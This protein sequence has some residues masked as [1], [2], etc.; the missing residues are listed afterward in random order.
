[1]GT[2]T[3]VPYFVLRINQGLTED[4]DIDA[5][6]SLLSSSSSLHRIK[7]LF[8]VPEDLVAALIVHP[9]LCCGSIF[10]LSLENSGCSSRSLAPPG[11]SMHRT[12]FLS[13]TFDSLVPEDTAHEISR[14][15]CIRIDNMGPIIRSMRTSN[16]PVDP[17]NLAKAQKDWV[18]TIL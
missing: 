12:A 8:T 2:K 6:S 16:V 14:R 17:T 10:S 18:K 3:T 5:P 15:L 9:I 4:G 11:K 13:T 7:A 1:M